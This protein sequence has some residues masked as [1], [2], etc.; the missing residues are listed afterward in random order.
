MGFIEINEK[1]LFLNNIDIHKDR[2]EVSSLG[3]DED[4]LIEAFQILVKHRSFDKNNVSCGVFAGP[5]FG[6]FSLASR[7]WRASLGIYFLGVTNCFWESGAGYS[8]PWLFNA[9][10]SIELYLKG[11]LLYVFWFGELQNN[12]LA[13]DNRLSLD[14][15][16][17]KFIKTKDQNNEIHN[18]AY[19][20]DHY[21]SGMERILNNWN[22]ETIPE[23]P[24]IQR[25]LLSKIGEELLKEIYEADKDSFRFR[26]PSMKVSGSDKLQELNWKY[27]NDELLPNT[28][29]PINSGYFF[30]HMK[31][32]N[33]LHDLM[34]E[35]VGIKS[36]LE[37]CWSYIGDIQSWSIE[38]KNEFRDF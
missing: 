15:L 37:A 33:S 13:A 30:D 32:I 20:Y 9:R 29:L 35:I 5:D 27:D 14:R 22:H 6:Y 12:V 36:Y 31:V 28:G 10:H 21:K 26:Y 38:L 34:Q 8:E 7:F 1:G 17:E 2:W 23:P 11:F 18:V 3:H 16:K 4:R 19:L 25:I 24:E